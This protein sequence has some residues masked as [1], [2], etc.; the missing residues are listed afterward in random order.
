MA[1][2][3]ARP[4]SSAHKA[5]RPAPRFAEDADTD[6]ETLGFMIGG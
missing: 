4:D 2:I 3:E 5:Q 6:L 1:D